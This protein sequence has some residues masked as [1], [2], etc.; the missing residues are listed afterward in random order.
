MGLNNRLDEKIL[1]PLSPYGISSN[2]LIKQST[3]IIFGAYDR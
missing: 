3:A 2:D 1:C